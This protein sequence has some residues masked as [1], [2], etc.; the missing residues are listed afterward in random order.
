[1]PLLHV[2]EPAVPY[3]RRPPLVIDASVLAAVLFAEPARAEAEAE[4]RTRRLFAPRLIDFEIANIAV[5]KA[6]TRILTWD[7]VER[8]LAL[9]RTLDL[10]REDVDPAAMARLAGHYGLTAYDAAYL[11]LAESMQAPLATFDTALGKAAQ[12]HLARDAE[13]EA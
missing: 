6:R 7:E 10:S 11:C 4:L 12:L 3:A 1:M 2:A 9:F 13:P 8:A 5:I